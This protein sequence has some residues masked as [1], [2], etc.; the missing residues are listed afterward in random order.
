MLRRVWLIC[1]AALVIAAQPAAVFDA[2]SVRPS[3]ARPVVYGGT[4]GVEAP[5]AVFE[6][7]GL[8]FTGRN[9]NLYALIVE[10]YGLKFCRPLA[11]ACPMLSGG[12]AWLARDVFDIQAK[13]PAGSPAYTTM[14]LRTAAAPRLQEMLRNLLADRFHLKTHQERRQL[15]VYA[16]TVGTSGIRMTKG[17]AGAKSSVIFRPVN[18]PSGPQSTRVVGS[19]ATVQDLADLYTKFMDRPVIDMTGLSGRFDFSVE[20]EADPDTTGPFAALTSPALFQA[21]EQQ[22]GLRLR[23]TQGPVDVLIVDSASRPGA[24]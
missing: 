22:A 11:D 21:F 4:K 24:N 14:Q 8:T 7:N 5:A 16:F 15:P 20:Y 1:S 10:A 18:T 9:L 17:S 19:N 3:R 2:A 6:V 13:A 12:P 23:A